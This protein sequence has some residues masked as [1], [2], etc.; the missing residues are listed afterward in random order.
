LRTLFTTPPSLRPESSLRK[1]VSY[2][3]ASGVAQAVLGTIGDDEALARNLVYDRQ[4]L[5]L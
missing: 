2:L 5:L 3:R 4:V 1:A